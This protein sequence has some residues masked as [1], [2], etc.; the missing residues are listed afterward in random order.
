M[1][2]RV[3]TMGSRTRCQV[4]SITTLRLLRV[5]ALICHA[6][7]PMPDGNLLNGAYLA[8]QAQAQAPQLMQ[9]A[10]GRAAVAWQRSSYATTGNRRLKATGVS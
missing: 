5:H 3:V 10:Y 9:P 8:V 7:D 4:P 6:V 2:I 1:G